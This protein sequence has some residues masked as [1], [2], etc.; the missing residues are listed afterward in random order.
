MGYNIRTKEIANHEVCNRYATMLSARRLSNKKRQHI[1]RAHVAAINNQRISQDPPSDHASEV[2]EFHHLLRDARESI[3]RLTRRD[4]PPPTDTTPKHPGIASPRYAAAYQAAPPS[5]A[6]IKNQA[7]TNSTRGTIPASKT[8]RRPTEQAQQQRRS[9]PFRSYITPAYP[10]P[11]A[12][13]RVISFIRANRI[14]FCHAFGIPCVPSTN[15]T[16]SHKLIPEGYYKNLP[17]GDR[18]SRAH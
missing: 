8:W 9:V 11:T 15:R 7:A 6:A 10:A 16:Y 18:S 2:A 14:C 13:G 3:Y 12:T 5:L 1:P 4:S 17:Q